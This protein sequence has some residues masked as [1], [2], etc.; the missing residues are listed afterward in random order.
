MSRPTYITKGDCG[1]QRPD[2]NL[3]RLPNTSA[4]QPPV[5]GKCV[6]KAGYEV[7]VPRTVYDLEPEEGVMDARLDLRSVRKDR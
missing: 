5:C 4:M 2:V 7:P 3:Y 6:E 1:C